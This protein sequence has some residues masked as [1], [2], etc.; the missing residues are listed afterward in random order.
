MKKL[1]KVEKSLIFRISLVH[2]S[3]LMIDF[4]K[5]LR[6]I[7]FRVYLFLYLMITIIKFKGNLIEKKCYVDYN[8]SLY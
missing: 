4:L 8:F 2:I 5:E 3:L 7:I 1:K 6:I